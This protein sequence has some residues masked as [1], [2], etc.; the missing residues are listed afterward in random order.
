MSTPDGHV[1]ITRQDT[2]ESVTLRLAKE[3]AK[4]QA[5]V[6]GWQTQPLPFSE[7]ATY[8]RAPSDPRALTI[9]LMAEGFMRQ[10]VEAVWRQLEEMG[11]SDDREVGEDAAPPR[12]RVEGMVPGTR[13]VW[14]MADLDEGQP[15]WLGGKKGPRR[16]RQEATLSLIRPRETP[17]VAARKLRSA[18]T[19]TG[20]AKTR[21]ARSVAHD[22]LQRIALRE[23][24][25]ATRWDEIYDMNRRVVKGKRKDAPFPKDP[26]RI[27]KVGTVV[28]LPRR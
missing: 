16:C 26:R 21:T 27:L 6:G 5:A 8:W 23:L 14:V 3:P 7:P 10:S 22:T 4:Y 1:T 20:K 24:G 18:R 19:S 25:D 17:S 11:E 28:K 2:G 15:V 9:P 12:L 13:H